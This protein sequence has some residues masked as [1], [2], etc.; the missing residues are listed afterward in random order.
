VALNT[1]NQP[2]IMVTFSG[3]FEWP[4]YTGLA[5]FI[6]YNTLWRKLLIFL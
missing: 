1:I 4:L 2:T 3:S 5:Y 6:S